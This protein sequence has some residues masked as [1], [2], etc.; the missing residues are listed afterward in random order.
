MP[1]NS[2]VKAYAISSAR[3]GRAQPGQD[4]EV[5][6]VKG[7]WTFVGLPSGKGKPKEAAEFP[8]LAER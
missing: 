6:E 8:G 1:G 2:H 4:E 5:F 7:G 3:L